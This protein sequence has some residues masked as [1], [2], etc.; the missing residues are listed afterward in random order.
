MLERIGPA[1]AQGGDFMFDVLTRR[2]QDAGDDAAHTL[3]DKEGEPVRRLTYRDLLN[4][5]H[6]VAH[7]LAGQA[8]PGERALLLYSS[9]L[10]F[11]VAFF[12]C[13]EAGIIAVPAP[14]PEASRLKR[15]MPRLAAIVADAE[16]SLL[17]GDSPV[18]S[19]LETPDQRLAPLRAL[20]RLN[21][22]EIPSSETRLQLDTALPEVAYLQYTSGSISTPKGAMVGHRG[23]MGNLEHNHHLWRYDADSVAVHWMPYFHDYGLV[24]GLLQP[25]FAGIPAYVIP[26]VAFLRRPELWL[27]AIS[28]Y[29]ATHS[30][31]PN[32]GYDYCVKRIAP[33]DRA[34]LDLSCWRVASNG[35]EVVR[36]ETLDGFSEAFAPHGFSP[37]AF[38][39]SYGLA[40]ATLLLTASASDAPPTFLTVDAEALQRGEAVPAEDGSRAMTVVG[41]GTAGPGADIRIVDPATR[42]PCAEGKVGEIWARG[43]GIALGYWRRE[44]ESADTFGATIAGDASRATY[45]RTGDAGFVRDG[46]LFVSGRLKDV[47][48]IR[49]ANHF[50]DDIESTVRTAHPA[51][52]G[53]DAAAFA[54][55]GESSDSLAVVIE[56]DREVD[57][58][59]LPEIHE[60]VKIAVV[61]AHDVQVSAA[62]YIRRGNL[63]KTS[64]GKIQRAACRAAF[65]DHTLDKELARFAL[66]SLTAK[67]CLPEARLAESRQRAD[68]IIAALQAFARDRLNLRLMD[69][70]RSPPPHV[71]L[72]L[73]NLGVLGLQAPVAL[74]G[75][76]LL[77]TD[78][79]RVLEQVGAIDL[80]LG[81]MATLQNGLGLRPLLRH[82]RPEQQAHLLPD[83]ARGRQ[84][85]AFAYT[86]EGAGS[87]IRAIETTAR[88]AGDGGFRLDGRKIWSGSSAWASVIHVFAREFD[89]AGQPAGV[90]AFVADRSVPGLSCGEESLTMGLNATIQNAVELDGAQL[91]EDTRLG[92][93]GQGLAVAQ[94]AMSFTRLCLAAL[95]LGA[96]RRLVR[97]MHRYAAGRQ[98]MTGALIDHPL[99]RTTIAGHLSAIGALEILVRETARLEDETGGAPEGLLAACKILAPE[100]L[101]RCADD[102][103]QMLG[104]RGYMEHNLVAAVFRD[105]R[106]IRIFEGPTEVLRHHLGSGVLNAPDTTADLLSGTLGDDAAAERLRAFARRMNE[107]L[108]AGGSGGEARLWIAQGTGEAAAWMLLDALVRRNAADDEAG[109]RLQAWTRARAAAAE[110]TALAGTFDPSATPEPDA[111]AAAV[112]EAAAPIGAGGHR[113]AGFETA[114]DAALDEA[115]TPTRANAARQPQ[116]A[117]AP[118]AAPAA[119][120]ADRSG[121]RETIALWI[122]DWIARVAGVPRG[123]VEA[124]RAMAGFGMDSV[125]AVNLAMDLEQRFDR[126]V[127]AT[128]IWDYPTIGKLAAHLAGAETTPST[129]RPPAAAPGGDARAPAAHRSLEEEL[130]ALLGEVDEI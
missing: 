13:L 119:A 46:E 125:M 96:M 88:P 71:V 33:E 22:T 28:R 129:A 103:V 128:L 57:P 2:A 60:A 89:A 59:F 5:A 85:V 73:G 24:E 21:T 91:A 105:A 114:L 61:D 10:D 47:I 101:W 84:L 78:A 51:L 113:A 40:E 111:L 104:G 26:T 86:E 27:R 15:T 16:A 117:P 76:G 115:P 81:V 43:A 49:G 55:S 70:R 19:L 122:A 45:L 116:P 25:I 124:D 29:R 14:P 123:S 130:D 108:A 32:F 106:A 9:P 18:M 94:D 90:S 17:L 100:L 36:H 6:G 65:L 20:E 41:C 68:D 44:A 11:L 118:T 82:G 93:R 39:P 58:K 30:A 35:A 54:V 12:G 95:S 66:A 110:E 31:S 3:L 67:D 56:V 62:A 52:H 97:V 80:S 72:E 7:R 8:E 99:I 37:N 63:L 127:D 126:P 23:L 69:E 75:Q 102:A 98:V 112:A 42:T 87:N 48:V 53:S 79:M 77:A 92:E 74:G 64:S 50:P 107:T 121:E 109:R 1:N 34:G 83:L 38:V 4:R 120:S